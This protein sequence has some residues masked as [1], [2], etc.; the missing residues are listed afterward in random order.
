MGCPSCGVENPSAARF[1]MSCG[2]GLPAACPACGQ[3]NPTAARFCMQCGDLLMPPDRAVT[4]PAASTVSP[5]AY[6]PRHLAEK[7]L[8]SRASLEGERKQVTA[9]FVDVVDSTPLAERLG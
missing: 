4:D 9:L 3:S 6:T 7:I 1:C 2:T 5:G 8:R